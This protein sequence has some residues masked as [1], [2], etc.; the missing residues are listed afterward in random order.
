M[1]FGGC[2]FRCPFCHNPGLVLPSLIEEQKEIPPS[3]ILEE[4]DRRKKLVSG[5]VVSGGEPTLQEDL[6]PFLESLKALGF[7]VKLDTNGSRPQVL[8]EA[9]KAGLAD[10]VALDIKTSPSRYPQVTR[11]TGFEAVREAMAV[12]RELAPHYILRTTLVPGV[13]GRKEMIEIARLAMGAPEY[14]LQPFRNSHTL[15]PSF[16][17]LRPYPPSVMEEMAHILE[18]TVEKVVRCW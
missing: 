8:K 10:V 3:V 9:L 18:D 5:V 13:V 2:N 17:A 7:A 12:V 15:D 16:S 11:G 1:F 14:H 4:L 6:L